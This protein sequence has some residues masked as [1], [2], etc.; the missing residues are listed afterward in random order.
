MSVMYTTILKENSL[1]I[2][3]IRLRGEGV[4]RQSRMYSVN[5][6][7]H[8]TRTETVSVRSIALRHLLLSLSLFDGLSSLLLGGRRLA[9]LSLR[10]RLRRFRSRSTLNRCVRINDGSRH[11]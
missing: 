4:A 5:N 6:E 3:Y 10:S 9:F 8:G 11:W 7:K 2:S 1:Y